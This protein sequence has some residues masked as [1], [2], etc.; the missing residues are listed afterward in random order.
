MQWHS[1]V[2]TVGASH[3]RRY[4]TDSCA[5]RTTARGSAE[6][7]RAVQEAIA[8]VMP[9]AGAALEGEEPT[10]DGADLRHL[11]DVAGIPLA[12]IHNISPSYLATSDQTSQPLVLVPSARHN[13]RAL[14][15]ALVSQRPILLS[16]AVGSGK[17]TTV[18][19]FC[20]VQR[21][22]KILKLQMGD[23]VDG[24]A[25]L[26]AYVCTDV[27]GEFRSV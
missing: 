25:L 5:L 26:G 11:I 13:L 4:G 10:V 1:C 19:H 2:D 9:E 21:T 23:Q 24:K 15:L 17:T 22:D 14:A 7:Y 27:P 18:E 20:G 8:V 12:P 6:A 3:L 16:G